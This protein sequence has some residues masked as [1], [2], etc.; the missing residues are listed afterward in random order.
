MQVQRPSGNPPLR[1]HAKPSASNICAC[2]MRY[3]ASVSN[4]HRRPSHPVVH[5]LP[6]SG[7]PDVTSSCIGKCARGGPPNV[8]HPVDH[9]MCRI[10][11][12]TRCVHAVDH[13]MCACS[14]VVCTWWKSDGQPD[15]SIEWLAFGVL[16]SLSLFMGK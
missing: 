14:A 6:T 15:V 10:W 5:W 7:P 2:V 3:I 11:W 1:L 16:C 4:I 13:W 8:P 12:T 9:W